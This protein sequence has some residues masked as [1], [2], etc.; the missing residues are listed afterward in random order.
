MSG[1]PGSSLVKRRNAL[2][3]KIF[4]TPQINKFQPQLK[5]TEVMPSPSQPSDE[6]RKMLYSTLVTTGHRI[7]TCSAPIGHSGRTLTSAC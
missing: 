1:F 2:I 5:H 6:L 7:S 3:T 4:K